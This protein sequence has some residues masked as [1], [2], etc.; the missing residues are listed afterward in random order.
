MAALP[1][2]AFR[3]LLWFLR[4]PREWWRPLVAYGITI[5]AILAVAVA[6]AWGLWPRPEEFIGTYGYVRV[7]LAIAGGLTAAVVAGAGLLP[8]C[9]ALA[10]DGLVA[11]IRREAGA[12][13]VSEATIPAVMSVLVVILGT[14]WL[15]LAMVAVTLLGLFTGPLAPF[16]AAW[17]LSR[18]AVV[19]ALD[20]ALAGEGL[21]GSQRLVIIRQHQGAAWREALEAGILKIVLAP[22]LLGWFLWMPA[23][24]AG[25]TLQRLAALP[26]GL[27][28]SGPAQKPTLPPCPPG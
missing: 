15:R 27:R 6:V 11:A 19:D 17:A 2:I 25:A 5:L 9:L 1:S 22:T 12:P 14:L 8:L 23:L 26:T 28:A 3:G 20:T 21:S 10:F 7:G 13:V 24:V 16:V 4:H 18:V